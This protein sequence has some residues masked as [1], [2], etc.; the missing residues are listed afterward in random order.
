[1]VTEVT[2]EKYKNLYGLP[3][4]EHKELV[5]GN[6]FSLYKRKHYFVIVSV[7]NL[8]RE[9]LLVRDLNKTIGLELPGGCI[10][11][12][13]SIEEAVNRVTL[14]EIG[15]DIDELSPVAIIKNIFECNGK[16]I[17]HLGIA[18]MALSRGTIK[19]SQENLQAFFVSG[20]SPKLAYQ[21]SDI[22]SLVEEKLRTKSQ[23]PLLGKS[24]A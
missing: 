10:N 20:V 5:P 9:T 3:E 21:N 6:L 8:K 2:I 22:L 18:F 14:D 7:Y 23:T 24:I 12:D 17:V 11:N 1:M 15:L 13:E 19:S 16:T 4:L